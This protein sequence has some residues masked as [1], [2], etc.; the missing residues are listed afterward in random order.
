M[1]TV[2][3]LCSLRP[4]SA[5]KQNTRLHPCCCWQLLPRLNSPITVTDSTTP[6][7]STELLT[8]TVTVSPDSPQPPPP[9]TP[10]PPTPLTPPPPTPLTPPPLPL[11][12]LLLP[13][14][15]PLPPRS[16]LLPPTTDTD[17]PLA[18]T[19]LRMSSDRPPTVMPT[20]DRL[21]PTTKM[22]SVTRSEAT[23]TSTPKAKRSA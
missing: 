17:T 19:A 13:S 6:L 10:P 20:P 3:L 7:D 1:G 14:L 8:T 11:P 9:L 12:S 18:S 21:L 15:P 5:S 22:L 2:F 23:L 4:H 16:L